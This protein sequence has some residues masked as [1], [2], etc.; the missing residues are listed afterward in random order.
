MVADLGSVEGTGTF[1]GIS[2]GGAPTPTATLVTLAA[3]GR[4]PADITIPTQGS[5]DPV[6]TRGAMSASRAP[7]DRASPRSRWRRTPLRADQRNN[8]SGVAARLSPEAIQLAAGYYS[9]PTY[10]S[11]RYSSP[12]GDYNAYLEQKLIEYADFLGVDKLNEQQMLEFIR[13]SP[14]GLNFRGEPMRLSG[15]SMSTRSPRRRR[16]IR[17]ESPPGFQGP[18]SPRPNFLSKERRI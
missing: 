8:E 15:A 1:D 13:K 11:H 10:P 7:R 6:P 12:H 5:D 14:Q 16:L 2:Q 3:L 18:T 4:N 9:G 17:L